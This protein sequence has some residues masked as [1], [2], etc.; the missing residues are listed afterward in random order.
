MLNC[1]MPL[2]PANDFAR[3]GQTKLTTQQERTIRIEL[4]I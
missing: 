1:A 3:P 2:Q 4:I